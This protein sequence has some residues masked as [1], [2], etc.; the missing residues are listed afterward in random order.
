MEL[1]KGQYRV[2][3]VQFLVYNLFLTYSS[4]ISQEVFF[5]SSP[6]ML[7]RPTG[8]MSSLSVSPQLL[9]RAYPVQ[10]FLCFVCSPRAG[11]T[12]GSRNPCNCKA[13]GGENQSGPPNKHCPS[14]TAGLVFLLPCLRKW[15]PL[16]P[17]GLQ[18]R[19]SGH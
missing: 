8:S 15:D 10:P 17:R 6:S 13:G 2:S 1:E 9:H 4:T 19:S 3:S 16:C 14:R 12:E 18:C 5:S 7:L 11:R